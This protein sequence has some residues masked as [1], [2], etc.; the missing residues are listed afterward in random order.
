MNAASSPPSNSCVPTRHA[1]PHSTSSCSEAGSDT[2]WTPPGCRRSAPCRPSPNKAGNAAVIGPDTR[3]R[4]EACLAES[5]QDPDRPLPVTARGAR[6]YLDICFFHPFDDGNACS[7]LL[8]LLFVIA[9]EG[10]ALDD[11]S[12]LRRITFRA[13]EPRDA[14]T[15]TRYIDTHLRTTRRASASAHS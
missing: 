14:M 2:S 3:A 9:R 5:A 12:L 1:A 8:A 6:V 4:F 13:D 15:L 7:A 11:V 10:I